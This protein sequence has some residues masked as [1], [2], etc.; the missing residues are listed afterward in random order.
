MILV[1]PQSGWANIFYEE[2][3]GVMVY[4]LIGPRGDVDG[5]FPAVTTP[6]LSGDVFAVGW[7]E[8]TQRGADGGEGV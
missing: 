7:R 4:V 2:S 1:N 8:V 5:P 3:P 6:F